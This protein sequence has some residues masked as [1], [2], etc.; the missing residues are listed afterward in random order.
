VFFIITL[1][2]IEIEGSSNIDS[3]IKKMSELYDSAKTNYE[4]GKFSEAI[5]CLNKVVVLKKG[6]ERDIFPE[7]YKIF[8]R[9]G[10]VYKKKGVLNKA[11]FY[12][13][14]TLEF[15]ITPKNEARVLMNIANVYALRGDYSLAITYFNKVLSI[16]SSLEE[17]DPT[18]ISDTYYNIGKAYDNTLQNEL[19]LKFFLLSEKVRKNAKLP[20]DGDTY[21]N[22]AL[23]YNKLGKRDTAKIYFNKAIY[24]FEK[25]YGKSHYRTALAYMNYAKFLSSNKEYKQAL[26]L[27]YNSLNLLENNIGKKH[28]YISFCYNNLGEHYMKQKEYRKALTFFQE[29]LISIVYDF[30]DTSI[31]S[32]PSPKIFSSIDLLEVLTNKALAFERLADKE[33]KE[34]NLLA[35]IKTLELKIK[36]VDQL[37]TGYL[38][39]NTKLKLSEN[40]QD[41]YLVLIRIANKLYHITKQ[42]KY[43]EAAFRYSEKSKYSV[44]REFYN[45]ESLMKAALIPDSIYDKQKSI[46]EKLSETRWLIENENGQINPDKNKMN[47]L[48][49]QLFQETKALDSLSRKLEKDYANYVKLKYNNDVVDIKNLQSILRSDQV[50]FEYAISDSTL[51]TFFFS[52]D[53][54]QMRDVRLDKAFYENLD[55]YNRFLNSVISFHSYDSFR[56]SAYFLYQTFLQPFLKEIEG[57]SLLIIPDKEFALISFESL[58]D[59]PFKKVEY[60]NY[61]YE[62]YI[63]RKYPIGYAFSASLYAESLKRKHKSRN[64]VLAFAPSYKISG[65]STQALPF[66]TRHLRKLTLTGG[67]YYNKRKATETKLKEEIADFNIVYIYAHGDKD[68]TSNSN[69]YI[70]LSSENNCE[71]DG[72]LYAHEVANLSLNTKLIVLASCYSGYGKIS[73]GEGVLSIGR[74]FLSAGTSSLIISLWHT[75]LESS[76]KQIG[77]FQNQLL[78]GKNKDKA[79][80]YAKLK[81]LEDADELSG[82]PKEW[83]SLVI[84]GSQERLYHFFVLKALSVIIFSALLILLSIKILIRKSL[85]RKQ[86]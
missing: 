48:E 33:N 61:A 70:H 85:R 13:E 37:R 4:N 10:V 18:L 46:K 6:S 69:Y 9:Y 7:Y 27:F 82:H 28:L 49:E 3:D 12:F 72:L 44:L 1:S 62:P 65:D 55:Y 78:L 16:V 64:K 38:Y 74:N 77:I 54:F 23:D 75:T 29:S 86:L 73:R 30:N 25:E 45:E 8:N 22:C 52:S 58:I 2:S 43:A 50:A 80:Q 84:T 26:K 14:K 53:T 35:A 21:L 51:Y 39:E 83:A 79:L 56:I 34:V 59:E 66:L 68:T 36:L 17:V 76:T 31:Y 42:E 20:D 67:K 57:K 63:I 41:A 47:V 40:E 60:A 71:N 19:A 11:L 15:S 5:L 32:N 81:Y 24:S